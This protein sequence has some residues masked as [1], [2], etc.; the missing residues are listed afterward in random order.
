M[1]TE[2]RQRYLR[3]RRRKLIRIL[4]PPALITI[5]LI[6]GFIFGRRSVTIPDPEVLEC[7]PPIVCEEIPS[8]TEVDDNQDEDGDENEAAGESDESTQTPETTWEQ[9]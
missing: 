2:T 4:T 3:W 9:P 5:A 8:P 6:V 7:P 1:D